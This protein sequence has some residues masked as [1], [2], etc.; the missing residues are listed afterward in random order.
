[1][2]QRLRQPGVQGIFRADGKIDLWFVGLL[3]WHDSGHF[4]GF[5]G[6][7]PWLDAPDCAQR[8]ADSR[9]LG[10]LC[11][12][13]FGWLFGRGRRRVGAVF[14]ASD[15]ADGWVFNLPALD[16]LEFVKGRWLQRPRSVCIGRFLCGGTGRWLGSARI[17]GTGCKFCRKLRSGVAGAKHQLSQRH[18]R[19]AT[20][21]GC[22]G[23]CVLY[24]GGT[25]RICMDS[26]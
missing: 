5:A 25:R 15:C 7:L 2:T 4:G 9:D 20:G 16:H 24:F 26:A 12:G 1:M 3:F 14:G 18:K 23:Q 17:A 21:M 6:C 10:F 11:C 19:R 13:F 22:S 8:C